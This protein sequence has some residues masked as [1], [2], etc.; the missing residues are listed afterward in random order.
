MCKSH[1][2]TLH[3]LTTSLY[4]TQNKKTDDDSA[5]TPVNTQIRIPVLENDFDPEED[6]I[7][8]DSIPQQPT[9]GVAGIRPDGTIVYK[10][11][12]DFIGS[13]SF[14]YQICDSNGDCDTATVTVEV[15]A[16]PNTAPVAKDDFVTISEGMDPGPTIPVL[17]NDNDPDGDPLIVTEVGPAENG[18]VVSSDDEEGVVYTPNEDFTGVDCKSSFCV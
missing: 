3:C 7:S 8:I 9:N 18:E 16:L 5:T 2:L 14:T 13:D 4:L 11:D 12:P 15:E 6:P 1:I 10:P 17:V